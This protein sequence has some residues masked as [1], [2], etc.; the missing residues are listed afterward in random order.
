MSDNGLVFLERFAKAARVIIDAGDVI[1]VK[2]VAA[3]TGC[4][5]RQVYRYVK[6]MKSYDPRLSAQAGM[7]LLYNRNKRI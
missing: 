2:Q 7:G 1:T 6:I 5:Q 3:L 4:S